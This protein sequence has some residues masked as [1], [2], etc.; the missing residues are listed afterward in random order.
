M[1]LVNPSRDV[2]VNLD[3]AR[4]AIDSASDST[5]SGF[6][7]AAPQGWRG[8]AQA[9]LRITR[10]RDT[11][12]NAGVVPYICVLHDKLGMLGKVSVSP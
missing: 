12:P 5:Y 2:T 4:H 10:P 11:F 9:L 7:I 1:D 6:I 3:G 8:L